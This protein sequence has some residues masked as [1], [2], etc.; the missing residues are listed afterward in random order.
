MLP[1]K[2]LSHL[3]IEA[4]VD[5]YPVPIDLNAAAAEI[6]VRPDH[7]TITYTHIALT[8]RQTMFAPEAGA[9]GD[10]GGGGV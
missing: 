4:E 8:V 2:V 10:G 6:E 5:G 7:T 3:R 9:S 1:V